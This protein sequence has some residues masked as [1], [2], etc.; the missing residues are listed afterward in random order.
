MNKRVYILMIVSFV[1]GMVELIIGGILDLIAE[2]LHV[3]LGQAG[4]LIT[5]FSL[6]FAIGGPVL[7]VLSAGIERK[8][9]T[10]FSLGVFFL[11]NIV[12]ILSATYTVLFIG[13]IISALSGAL[14]VNL[15]L[16]MAP[17]IVQP[18]YRGRAIGVISMG[19]SGS[20]VLGLPIGLILGDTFNWRAPFILIAILTIFS[21][22]GVYFFMKKVHP[23][24][25]VPLKK[26]LLTLKD[27]KILFAHLSMFLFLAGH[28][29]LYA[30]F[31]PFLKTTMGIEGTL[32]SVI[33][34]IFGIAA[35]SGGGLGGAMADRFGTNRTILSTII[36]FGVTIFA[37]PYTTFS[38]AL[39]LIAMVIWGI[40]N[41]ALS[42]ALQ[43]YL[44]E[45]A[46]ETSDVQQSLNNSSLHFGIAFGSFVGGIIIEKTNVVQNAFAGGLIIV[47]SLFT[48]LISIYGGKSA[49]K[50]T[51][52]SRI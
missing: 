49:S 36:I 6:T 21:V 18:K 37:I 16:V 51:H 33:Y 52:R 48:A 29:V 17:S 31:K 22:I 35:V 32:V 20:I 43:S 19:I 45:T 24:P 5:I 2:D 8:K 4:F 30:Y 39:F 10:L 50:E 15:C 12:T 25:P 27:N 14:L 47:L 28:T 44:I 9:L 13:R 34:L 42:P 26:Q 3:S 7:L 11:G 38:L 23:R 46:P 41:W 1:V 40:V